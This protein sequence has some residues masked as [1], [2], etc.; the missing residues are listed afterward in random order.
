MACE[1]YKD[2]FFSLK[3]KGEKLHPKEFRGTYT[4]DECQSDVINEKNMEEL[5]SKYLTNR[6]CSSTSYNTTS[7]RSHAIF[8][9]ISKNFRIGVVDLA[10]S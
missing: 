9:I 10:G 4:F 3:I 8:K 2:E 7:S 1:L 6:S 5:F